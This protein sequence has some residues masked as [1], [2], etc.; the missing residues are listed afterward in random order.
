[1]GLELG[2]FNLERIT[3]E[4]L[5]WK[6]SGSGLELTSP[7]SGGRSASIVLLRTKHHGVLTQSLLKNAVSS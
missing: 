5:E 1:V 2:P 4:L 7:T 6:S 3:E